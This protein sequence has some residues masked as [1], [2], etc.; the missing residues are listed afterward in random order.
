MIVRADVRRGVAVAIT[1][2]SAHGIVE[3]KQSLH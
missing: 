3:V 1:D 2:D